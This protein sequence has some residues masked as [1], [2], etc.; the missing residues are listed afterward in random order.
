MEFFDIVK[1]NDDYPDEKYRG[2]E[3]VVVGMADGDPA[4]VIYALVF[5]EPPLDSIDVTIDEVTQ[6]G[7]KADETDV[8]PGDILHVSVDQE[9]ESR[10][11]GYTQAQ[12][13]E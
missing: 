7:R 10:I 9:G 8:Y 13:G 6:T 2:K 11:T 5:L 4:N 3:G 12:G 1:I